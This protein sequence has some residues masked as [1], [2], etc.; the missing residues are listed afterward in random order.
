MKIQ[1]VRSSHWLLLTVTLLPAVAILMYHDSLDAQV[2]LSN[3]L[4]V[5]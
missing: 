5:K 1:S 3:A 2:P 4:T